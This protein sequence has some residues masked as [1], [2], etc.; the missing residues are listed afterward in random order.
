MRRDETGLSDEATPGQRPARI[1]PRRTRLRQK[2]ETSKRSRASGLLVLL[3]L[4][5]GCANKA[6]GPEVAVEV[7]C[8]RDL[9]VEATCTGSVDG[10][11]AETLGLVGY[12]CS[13][14]AR[15][16]DRPAFVEGV[17]QGLVCANQSA[18]GDGGAQQQGYCCSASETTCALDPVGACADPGTYA[19]QCRGSNRPEAFNPEITCGQG[20]YEGDLIDYCCSGTPQ[21]PGCMQVDSVGCAPDLLGFRCTGTQTLPK[22]EELGANKSRADQYYLLCPVATPSTQGVGLYSY[23][24]FTAALVPPGGSCLQDTLVP[25]CAPGR[26]GIACTG[27]DTPTQDYPPLDCPDP[28]VPGTSSQGYPA[29]LYCCDLK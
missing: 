27:P 10:G 18:P 4:G 6:P 23:C 13:G 29:T 19:Y 9:A 22:G 26:Y 1:H 12:S 11:S 28:G 5:L 14:P 8:A 25:G 17:P 21:P 16:D 24:C 3:G 2:G 20:V 7:N 15:P